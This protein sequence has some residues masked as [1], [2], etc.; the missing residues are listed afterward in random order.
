MRYLM[1]VSETEVQGKQKHVG[2]SLL[3]TNPN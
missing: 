2:G 3:Y 1:T